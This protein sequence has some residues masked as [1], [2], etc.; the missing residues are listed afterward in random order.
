M[1][2]KAEKELK[3]RQD[4]ATVWKVLTDP[5]R[6]VVSVPGAELTEQLDERNFKG[7]VSV[8]I[9]PV[10]AKF[11]GEATFTK[12]DQTAH[13]LTL[14]GKGSDSGG[15]GGASMNMQIKLAS[16]EEGGTVMNSSMSLSISGKLAQFGSRMIVAVNNRMFD[17]WSDNFTELL[18]AQSAS[19]EI[20]MDAGETSGDTLPGTA[21]VHAEGSDSRVLESKPEPLKAL[22]LIWTAIKGFFGARSWAK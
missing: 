21:P 14:E 13:E 9:G 5:V 17:Q 6:M 2:V 1:Q 19:S 18:D 3:L 4:P 8:K 12:M 22:P 7:K 11:N 20:S 16:A 15:K 10:T